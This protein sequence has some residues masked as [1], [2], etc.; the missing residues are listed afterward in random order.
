M[1]SPVF[2]E[3]VRLSEVRTSLLEPESGL[4]LC[5]RAR[6]GFYTL[7]STGRKGLIPLQFVRSWVSTGAVGMRGPGGMDPVFK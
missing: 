6:L 1:L 5:E 7:W 4:L 3:T 2:S